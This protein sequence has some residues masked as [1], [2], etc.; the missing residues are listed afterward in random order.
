P[1]GCSGV[2]GAD[3]QWLA[4]YDPPP[5]TPNASAYTGQRPLIYMAYN[6]LASGSQWTKSHD[7]LTYVGAPIN[8]PSYAPFGADG[9]PAID[10]V[11]GK[12]F[13]ASGSGN[14]LLLNIGT[15]NADGDLTFLDAPTAAAPGG[16]SSKLIHIADGLKGGPDTLFSVLSMDSARNLVVAF[17][18]NASNPSDRQ[19][20]VSAASPTSGWTKW[21]A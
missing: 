5:G 12:V 1:A 16:D 11:S 15:P 14:S 9:Y 20:F 18:V 2:P 19:V 8:P 6:N 7:G 4:V 17:A 13:Q 10:Q 21:S 3:R